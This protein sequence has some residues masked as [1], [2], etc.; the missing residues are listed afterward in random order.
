MFLPTNRGFDSFFGIL[1]GG[2]SHSTKRCPNNLT[3]VDLWN[4]T[5]TVRMDDE[6]LRTKHHATDIFAEEASKI[7]KSSISRGK[8]RKP[9]FLML[10]FTAVHDPMIVSERY[11]FFCFMKSHYTQTGK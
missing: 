8:N 2:F 9:L 6:R 11:V 4:G 10:S 1:G 3:T 7:V 5:M